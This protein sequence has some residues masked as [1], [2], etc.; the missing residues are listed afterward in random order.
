MTGEKLALTAPAVSSAELQ[1]P[2]LL[3]TQLSLCVCVC[4]CVCVSLSVFDCLSVN[5]TCLCVCVCVCVCVC[6][7]ALCTGS[8]LYLKEV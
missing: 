8:L 7:G 6:P 1:L 5:K 4:V 2:N 3:H